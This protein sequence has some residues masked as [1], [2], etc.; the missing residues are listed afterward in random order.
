[1]TLTEQGAIH[2]SDRSS[3]SRNFMLAAAAA[4]VLATQVLGGKSNAWK[5]GFCPKHDFNPK[6]APFDKFKMAGPWYEYVWDQAFE[7][8]YRYKC[9]YWLF[10]TDEAKSGVDGLY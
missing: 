10:L 7:Q 6:R 1:M 3:S 2:A 5:P 8:D 4:A 9:G